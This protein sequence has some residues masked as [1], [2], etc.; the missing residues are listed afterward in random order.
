MKIEIAL[1][2]SLSFPQAVFQLAGNAAR[3]AGGA[4][5]LDSTLWHVIDIPRPIDP[6]HTTSEGLG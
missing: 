4:T 1:L 3:A 2:D 5:S 6:P